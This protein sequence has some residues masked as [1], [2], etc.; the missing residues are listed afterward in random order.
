MTRNNT[1]ASIIG[2]GETDFGEVPDK[3]YNDLNEQAAYEAMEQA[4]V[5]PDEVDG[6]IAAPPIGGDELGAVGASALAE[7]LGL[8]PGLKYGSMQSIGG[9][10]HIQHLLQAAEAI[11]SG[12][13]ENVLVLAAD[14]MATGLGRDAAVEAMAGAGHGEFETPYGPLI[15]SMYALAARKHMEEYG[16]TQEQLAKIASI[17]YE[18]ASLQPKERAQINESKTVE[19]V[20]ESPMIAT[21]LTLDQCSLVSDGGAALIVTDSESAHAD[22]DTPID[23]LSVGEYDTHESIHQMPDL[24]TTGARQA[25]KQ[26]FAA[27]DVEH[28]DLD[29]IQIYDCFTITVLEVLEDLGFCEKGEGGELVES[30]EL[31]LDG[32]WPMNTHGGELAQAHPGGPGGLMHI[33]EAVRQLWGEAGA[34]QVEDAETAL[35]HGNGGILSTQTVAI[36]ERGD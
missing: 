8:M 25:G 16:T 12:L 14:N 2:W 10:S 4:N 5:T 1:G 17:E 18:H 27:A 32:K 6:I 19:E 31:E 22:H 33:T 11:N 7:H 30:G 29:V 3:D 26:A 24:T 13:C 35:V 15:P 23:I 36:L 28:D 34:T 20:L 9:A 21:P